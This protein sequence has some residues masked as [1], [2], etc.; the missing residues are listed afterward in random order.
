MSKITR[1]ETEPSITCGFYNSEG[2]SKRKYDSLQMSSIFDGIIGEGIFASIGDCFAVTAY[3]GNIV[4]V[5]A[6]K[7]WFNH[8]WTVN[9]AILPVD[10]GES[11]IYL[12]RYDA[13]VIEV[14]STVEIRDNRIEVVKG[15]PSSSPVKPTLTNSKYVNQYPLCYIYRKAG[16]TEITQANIQDTVGTETPFI[17]GILETTSRY[18]WFAQWRAELDNFKNSEEA[19]FDAFM[20]AKENEFNEWSTDLMNESKTWTENH[21]NSFLAWFQEMK[22]QLSTDAA[23]NL[24]NEIDNEEIKRILMDGFI[25]GNKIISEDNTIITSTDSTGRTLTKT[26]T[27]NF[28]TSTTVLTDMFGSELGRLVKNF[29]SDG[30]AISS[31]VTIN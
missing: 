23:G 30:R 31:E 7:C 6:G 14:N 12:D 15:T 26:F 29:S 2:D 19:D 4:K 28:L 27:N 16:S 3:S 24:Q 11:D 13:V 25:E 10:C 5:G 9:D 21:K 22:D 8:T 1:P 17:T 20:T 18:D